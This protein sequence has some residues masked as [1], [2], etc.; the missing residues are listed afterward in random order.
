MRVEAEAG[1]EYAKIDVVI[2]RA[3]KKAELA[4]PSRDAKAPETSA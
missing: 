4:A 1:E 2:V 3:V